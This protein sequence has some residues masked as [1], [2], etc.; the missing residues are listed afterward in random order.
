MET[1]FK[2]TE[3]KRNASILIVDK[4]GVLGERI[5]EKLQEQSL[6]SQI[7]F[8]CE[9]DLIL[10]KESSAGIIYVPYKKRIP[11]IPD[12]AYSYMLIVYNGEWEFKDL[13]EEFVKE[14]EKTR[15]K[16]IF[17]IP[18]FL[19]TKELIESIVSSYKDANVILSGEL[20]G[21]GVALE[22]RTSIGKMFFLVREKEK[23]EIPNMGMERAYPVF[24]DDAVKAILEVFFQKN[25]E[26]RLFF[27][28]SKHAA[29]QLSI[30]RMIRKARPSIKI[31]F[32]NKSIVSTGIEIMLSY[33]LKA[34]YLLDLNYDLEERIKETIEF[35]ET[36]SNQN[37]FFNNKAELEPDIKTTSGFFSFKTAIFIIFSIIFLP[38][39]TTFLFSFIAIWQLSIAKQA[40][41]KG[42]FQTA[43]NSAEIS[44]KFFTLAGYT[45]ETVIEQAKLIKKNQQI[46]PF[47]KSIEV[48]R[49]VASIFISLSDGIEKYKNVFAFQTKNPKDDFL[50]GS[51]Y[52]KSALRTFQKIKA[53]DMLSKNS[54]LP[55]SLKDGEQYEKSIEFL[56]NTIDVLPELLGFYGK[57]NYLIL[58]QNNMELR[59]GGGFIGS[60][61]LLSLD[62]GTVADF[63][64]Q[65][66]YDADGQL[67]GHVEPP[68]PIRR[69]MSI[70]HWYL[71][72]SNFDPDFIK[73][74][75]ASAFFLKLETGKTVDGV[76]GI[77]VSVVKDL[78][79]V[80]GP[81][82]VSS[83]NET[84]D[85]DNVYLL[86]QT[87]AEKDFFPGSS[88]K[89]DFLRSLL[90]SMQLTL[91]SKKQFSYPALFAAM[92]QAVVQKH[93]VFA[94]ADSDLQ[95]FFTAN[96][97]SSSLADNRVEAADVV[98]DFLGIS[99]ANIGFNKANYFI[100]R[101]VDQNIK[102]DEDGSIVENLTISYKNT[103]TQGSWPGG[104]YKNYLRLILPLKTRITAIAINDQKQ[105]I[106]PA[107]T[108]ALVYEAKSF[109]APKG[110]E[111]EEKEEEGKS[112]F[113][114]LT[115]VPTG[116]LQTINISYIL[117]Q[118]I[119]KEELEFTYDLKLFS[120]PGV[121]EYPFTFTLFFPESLKAYSMSKE[122]KNEKNQIFLSKNLNSDKNIRIDFSSK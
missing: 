117:P 109:K 10:A 19:A 118:S 1:A 34:E 89:K 35:L 47:I 73:G 53:E 20:F 88:Q 43:K 28:F 55:V 69:Y 106:V 18:V 77:D 58:F 21:P 82:Y 49:D 16:L 13:M 116:K 66:V 90:N 38:I 63:S 96:S 3:D 44:E 100:K 80:L 6:A 91:S 39:I 94:M 92:A 17:V 50:A 98:N 23:L 26:P 61:G 95:H 97:L 37:K 29:T 113:G 54:F 68:F 65:D 122:L 64:I 7:V 62:K 8:L 76:I 107:V 87:H 102:F 67:K 40:V 52:L 79:R 75:S 42:D 114:F 115:V 56:G 70:V 81:V 84:V 30:A 33:F 31:D 12:S 48:G 108:D 74:A 93:I 36:T 22:N 4:Q 9:T 83:Y 86:T 15:A 24:I 121:E 120:Q 57:R 41:D 14:A 99:E 119:A 104:D 78:L 46:Q 32:V 71:R 25:P 5:I 111:V 60:Y 27:L 112:V 59:P 45:G 105:E 110:L 72:D 51:N 103:S 11:L 85:A 2:I 101:K